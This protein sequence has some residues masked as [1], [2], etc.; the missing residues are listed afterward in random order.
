MGDLHHAAEIFGVDISANMPAYVP[1]N[2]KFEIFDIEDEWSS[3][4]PFDYIHSRYMCGAF[5]DWP[6]L[7][8]QAFRWIRSIFEVCN[9]DSV[10]AVISSRVAGPSLSTY[11]SITTARMVL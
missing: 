8:A 2:F 7:M 11:R 4:L 9:A 1:P 3:S 6:R 5:K 10:N